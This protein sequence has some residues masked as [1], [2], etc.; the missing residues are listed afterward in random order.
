MAGLGLN[1][2]PEF[3]QRQRRVETQLGSGHCNLEPRFV[4]DLAVFEREDLDEIVHPRF[5]PVGHFID[6]LGTQAA[7]LAPVG[8]QECLLRDGY[9]LR[10]LGLPAVGVGPDRLAGSGVYAVEPLLG[11]DP[12]AADP[13]ARIQLS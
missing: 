9:R 10:G 1:R 12:F 11:V 3:R 6:R 5:E 4:D 13:V 8:I 7:V 2:A